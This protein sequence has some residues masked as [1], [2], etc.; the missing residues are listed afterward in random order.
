MSLNYRIQYNLTIADVKIAEIPAIVD[1]FGPK[2]LYLVKNPQNS[3][4]L[5]KR[6]PLNSGLTNSNI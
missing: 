2:N 5:Q 6:K 3:G 4:I 1:K